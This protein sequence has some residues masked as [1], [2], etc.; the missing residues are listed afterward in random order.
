MTARGRYLVGQK[1]SD[2]QI[3]KIVRAYAA[4]IPASDVIAAQEGTKSARA[5]NTIFSLYDLLRARLLEIGFYPDP[6][7]FVDALRDPEY[8]RGFAFSAMAKR[9]DAQGDRL[10]GV[11]D[12]T[13][14]A[15]LAE[16]L[17]RASNPGVTAERL[18]ADIKLAIK[19][20][21]PL[22]SPPQSQEVWSEL[23]Y[24]FV[25]QRQVDNLRRTKTAHPEGHRDIIAGLEGLIAGAMVRLNRAK[26]SEA[27]QQRIIGSKGRGG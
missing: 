1:L 24:V 9:L 11:P 25:I 8:A 26:R 10:Q 3:E 23:N 18:F 2:Y 20:T 14:P 22:N 17:F 5:P 19:I 21:G 6:Q 16:I 27:R 7:G 15:H 13:L 12:R 4:G